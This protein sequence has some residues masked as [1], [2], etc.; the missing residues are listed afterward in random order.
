MYLSLLCAP[1]LMSAS[2][3]AFSSFLHQFGVFSDLAIL[4][5]SVS[6]LSVRAALPTSLPLTN[7]WSYLLRT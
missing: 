7:C 3:P 2:L 4:L 5:V 1:L 6:I